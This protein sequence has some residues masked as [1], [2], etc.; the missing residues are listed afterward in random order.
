[1]AHGTPSCRLDGV[2]LDRAAERHGWRLVAPDRPGH[3]RSDPQPG[4]RLGDWPA[5]VRCLADHLGLERMALLGFSGGA[6]YALATARQLRGR[7]DVTGLVSPWG[8]PDRPGAYDGVPW[9]EQAFDGLA[10]RLPAAVAAAYGLTG[11]ALRRSPRWGEALLTGR[12]PDPVGPSDR[13]AGRDRPTGDARRDEPALSLVAP[14]RE[15]LRQGG[16]AAAHDLHL[17]VE[18]WGFPVGDVDGPVWIWHGDADHEVPLHHAEFLGRVLP[19]AHLEVVPGE[20]HRLLYARADA[21]L[22][23]LAAARR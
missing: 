15:A 4:R 5:D 20:G 23:A 9:G 2:L 11:M 21:V 3:G 8:P 10:R 17:V 19:G 13:V 1:M 6:P 14:L 7:V 18:P 12:L 16:S 22:G